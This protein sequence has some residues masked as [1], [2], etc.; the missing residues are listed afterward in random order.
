MSTNV[1]KHLNA[2]AKLIEVLPSFFP[3]LETYRQFRFALYMKI[4]NDSQEMSAEVA[5][6]KWKKICQRD[7]KDC[8]R[9]YLRND[10]F[11]EQ[12]LKNIS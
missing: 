7:M 12:F 8:E 4:M 3:N 5:F 2:G 11:I 6:L 1:S 10:S 9:D